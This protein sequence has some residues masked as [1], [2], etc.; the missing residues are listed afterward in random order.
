LPIT[1]EIEG[2]LFVAYRRRKA[3]LNKQKLAELLRLLKN[4]SVKREVWMD[5]LKD[6]IEPVDLTADTPQITGIT[7]DEDLKICIGGSDEP[8]EI[9]PPQMKFSNIIA[10][11]KFEKIRS[12]ISSSTEEDVITGLGLLKMLEDQPLRTHLT[13]IEQPLM[14]YGESTDGYSFV[15]GPML[16]WNVN[17]VYWHH[18]CPTKQADDFKENVYLEFIYWESGQITFNLPIETFEVDHLSL[19]ITEGFYGYYHC[20]A[21]LYDGV[22]Y[23][24]DQSEFF[25]YQ[26]GDV[27][28]YQYRDQHPQVI[29][30][31]GDSRSHLINILE[32]L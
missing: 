20:T 19:L 17:A 26:E 3:S 13:P 10:P 23:E 15:F 1:I 22:Q 9:T 28:I 32:N 16:I 30:E 6:L 8:Q 24:C 21:L 14:C 2:G 25:E 31:S 4:K 18:F 7:V 5:N 29:W 11:K 12:L 27:Y